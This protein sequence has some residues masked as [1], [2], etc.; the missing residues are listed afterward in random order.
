M[1]MQDKQYANRPTEAWTQLSPYQQQHMEHAMAPHC[2]DPP[3][4][5]IQAM[6]SNVGRP[7]RSFAVFGF[8]GRCCLFQL[9]PAAPCYSETYTA[10]SAYILSVMAS[11]V[12]LHSIDKGTDEDAAADTGRGRHSSKNRPASAAVAELQDWPGP[13]TQTAPAAKVV[14]AAAERRA[15]AAAGRGQDALALLWRLLL[16]MAKH[17]GAVQGSKH[18]APEAAILAL[19]KQALGS[20]T[21]VH[22]ACIMEARQL[23]QWAAHMPDAAGVSK[24]EELLMD[25]DRAAALVAATEA[26]ARIDVCMVFGHQ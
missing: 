1:L 14:A 25:G 15:A 2:S 8:G 21:D 7:P 4:S 6:Y 19:V 20:T 22:E 3:R 12:L 24:I 9:P 17:K 10:S 23:Q 5:L 18:G 26:Q 11:R 16:V 13:M